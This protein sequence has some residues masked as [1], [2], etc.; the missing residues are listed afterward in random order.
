M[1]GRIRESVEG[2]Y[3]FREFSP[4]PLPMNVLMMRL[5]SIIAFL[6]YFSDIIINADGVFSQSC[7]P[8][9]NTPIDQ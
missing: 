2:L 9:L 8:Y 1:V 4:P 5:K 3:N 6:K 7:Y